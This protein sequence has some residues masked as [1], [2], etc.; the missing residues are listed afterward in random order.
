M[1]KNAIFLVINW[2]YSLC[3]DWGLAIVLITIMFRILILPITMRQMKTT[4]V[5]QK[6]QPKIKEIQEKY[7]D[8]K[9]RQQEEM[10]KVYSEAKFNPLSGC[11]PMLLQMP[12]F[13]ALFQVLREL[14]TL[15][16]G[17]G[18]PEYVL[19]ARF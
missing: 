15:I 7:A 1:F 11:L 10:M 17:A 18:H 14:D 5:M 3:G 6:M 13:M 2:L 8:D 12:I 4:Y 9:P 16:S 19:P